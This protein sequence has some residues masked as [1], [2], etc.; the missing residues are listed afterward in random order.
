MG[1]VPA[2]HPNPFLRRP[3][4]LPYFHPRFLFFQ[5]PP[6]PPLRKAIKTY[7]PLPLKM[8]RT[9]LGYCFIVFLFCLHFCL[10]SHFKII[11]CIVKLLIATSTYFFVEIQLKKENLKTVF[12]VPGFWAPKRVYW[13]PK[14]LEYV[15]VPNFIRS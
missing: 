14:Q 2:R 7:S 9:K 8:G 6:L 15:T 10:L 3:A 1:K 5:I 13:S 11:R 4:P 12:W